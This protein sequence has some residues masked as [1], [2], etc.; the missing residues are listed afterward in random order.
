L[1]GR[2][3]SALFVSI[4]A[5]ST[6]STRQPLLVSASLFVAAAVFIAGCGTVNRYF[7]PAKFHRATSI[8]KP[9]RHYY[10]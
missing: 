4:A 6:R 9:L 7:N 10:E 3:R 2:T 5:T 8:C 1:T